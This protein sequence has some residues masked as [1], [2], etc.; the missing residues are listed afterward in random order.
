MAGGVFSG[1]R[2]HPTGQAY[3][4]EDLEH[5]GAR[6]VHEAADSLVQIGRAAH[7]HPEDAVA[8]RLAAVSDGDGAGP[9]ARAADRDDLVRGDGTRC[10]PAPHRVADQR[11]PGD[12][13]LRRAAAGKPMRLDGLM[14]V[15]Q[16][17]AAQPDEADLRTAGAEIDGE[18]DVVGSHGAG[19][20]CIASSRS[21]ITAR[22]SAS[23]SSVG[24]SPK[25]P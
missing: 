21:V 5:V 11:P 19:T 15:P 20:A 22:I 3:P 18:A 8:D 13:I 7:V 9:L 16:D 6:H 23:A 17:L 25:P 1:N 14:L 4:A 24:V 10:E 12:C 2:R